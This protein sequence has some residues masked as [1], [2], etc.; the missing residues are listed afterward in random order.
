MAGHNGIVVERGSRL[1]ENMQRFLTI[2]VFLRM[3]AVVLLGH[4]LS[5]DAESGFQKRSQY[6]KESKGA[7]VTWVQTG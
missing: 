1:K 4:D 7:F 2:W 6:G 5:H 3:V